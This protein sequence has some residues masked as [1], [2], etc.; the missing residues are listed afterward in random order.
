[1]GIGGVG[2]IALGAIGVFGVCARAQDLQYRLDG[3]AN[4]GFTFGYRAGF[5]GDVDGDGGDDFFVTDPDWNDGANSLAGALFVISGKT[6]ALLWSVKGAASNDFLGEGAAALADLDGDGFRELA[7]GGE[8]QQ[9]DV[10]SARTGAL[11]RS[12][13]AGNASFFGTAIAALGDADY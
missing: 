7:V 4:F 10:Y 9:V 6:G 5:V 2:A 13:P 1:M 12:H 11:L 8:Y 3:D